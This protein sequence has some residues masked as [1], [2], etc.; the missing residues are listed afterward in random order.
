MHIERSVNLANA[1]RNPI[2]AAAGAAPA[3]LYET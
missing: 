1:P 2:L 3:A